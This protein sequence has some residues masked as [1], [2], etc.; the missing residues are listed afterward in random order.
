MTALADTTRPVRALTLHEPWASLIAYRVKTIETRSWLPPRS[1]SGG[2]TLFV[3]AGKTLDPCWETEPFYSTLWGA[4][5]DAGRPLRND[6][7]PLGSI[8]AV[9]N[10]YRA[11]RHPGNLTRNTAE[12][13]E[14][15][16]VF[17]PGRCYWFLS[18]TVD[19]LPQPVPA[20]GRQGLWAPSPELV[21]KVRAQVPGS[22]WLNDGLVVS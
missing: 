16:G 9:A 5:A 11:A 22:V 14:P 3:H 20:K 21:D 8:V 12:E 18:T 17:G 19:R 10:V 1:L 2:F 4:M 7:F 6:D 13:Q 15:W